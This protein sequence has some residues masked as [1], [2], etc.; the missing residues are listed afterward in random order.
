VLTG[1][2]MLEYSFS[3]CILGARVLLKPINIC[4]TFNKILKL[5]YLS[6]ILGVSYA[7]IDH[8][9]VLVKIF[10]LLVCTFC[11]AYTAEAAAGYTCLRVRFHLAFL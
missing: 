5:F 2:Y 1:S 6:E 10:W 4:Y 9:Y 7:S 8:L 11:I 3:W